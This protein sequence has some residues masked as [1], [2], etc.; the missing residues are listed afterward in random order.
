VNRRN[1]L[2]VVAVLLPA[3]FVMTRGDGGRSPVASPAA[4]RAPA[5]SALVAAAPSPPVTSPAVEAPNAGTRIVQI[6][7]AAQ[8]GPA[9]RAEPVVRLSV[10]APAFVEPGLPHELIVRISAPRR[11]RWVTFTI[12]A[13]PDLLEL[14]VATRGEWAAR[15]DP[16]PAFEARISAEDNRIVIRAEAGDQSSAN[17]SASIAIVQFEG[18]APGSAT[19]TVSEIA[20]SDLAGARIPVA[21]H[22][23]KAEILV[24]SGPI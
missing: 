11:A 23:A 16:T 4:S 14:V 22:S 3:A 7:P 13:D 19:V 12:S 10:S 2:V 24:M 8:S 9:D 5:T 21:A 1:W 18:M 17:E 6:A 15:G 20:A